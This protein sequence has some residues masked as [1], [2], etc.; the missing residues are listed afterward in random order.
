M[1]SNSPTPM[2]GMALIGFT[3]MSVTQT[4]ISESAKKS[5]ARGRMADM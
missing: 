1:Q 4:V 2:Q 3:D 5:T